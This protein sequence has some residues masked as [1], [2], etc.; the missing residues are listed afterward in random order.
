[1]SNDNGTS[2]S[3]AITTTNDQ[4]R[5][6]AQFGELSVKGIVARKQKILE[7]M[8]SVMRDGQHYG[9]IP[10]CGDKPTLYKAGAEILATTF[11]LAPEF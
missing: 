2:T 5:E 6:L 7:I 4:P 3:K 8:Q 11:A 1:M 9:K 10:G